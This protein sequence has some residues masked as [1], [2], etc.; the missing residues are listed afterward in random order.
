MPDPRDDGN[1]DT[2]IRELVARAVAD[3]P[4]PPAIDPSVLPG[5][6]P[7]H[8]HHRGWW[9]GGGAAILAAAALVTA[10][11]LV[12][13]T[14]DKVSTPATPAP[15]APPTTPPTSAPSGPTTV[16]PAAVAVDAFVTAGPDGVVEHR[17][18]ESR[19]LTT[20]PMAIALDAGDGRIIMQR[21]SGNGES[22]GWTDADTIPLVLA[23]DGTTR[24]LLGAAVWEDGIVLHDI[25]VVGG[26]RLLLYSVQG[27]AVPQKP[28]ENLFVVDLETEQGTRVAR[29]IGGWEFGTDRLHLATTGLIV[30]EWSSEASHGIAF[31]AVPGSPADGAGLPTAADLGLED[32]Y[33]DCSDCPRSFTV[34]PDGRTIAW[35]DSTRGLV[36]VS[37][38][39][40]VGEHE[41]LVRVPRAG[42]VRDLDVGD[43]A[44]VMSFFSDP[45]VPPRL[46]ELDGSDVVTLTGTTATFGPTG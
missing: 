29:N 17:G 38:G 32:S 42:A 16:P 8:D 18:G 12:G 20:E 1:L 35:V 44:A 19:T 6:E 13:D 4:A 9:L 11:L 24:P 3:A 39:P 36:E 15:T 40:P 5:S 45:A 37:L 22:Q 27:P 43:S 28:N 41:V 33:S 30:G 46:V 25:E 31:Y 2:R 7:Q 10:L 34:R 14:G 26:H 23:A 21:R